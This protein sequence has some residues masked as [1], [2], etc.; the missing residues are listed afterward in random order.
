M[1]YRIELE[2]KYGT[3]A[4][5]CVGI[6]EAEATKLSR[7]EAW[8]DQGFSLEERLRKYAKT[9]W[10]SWDILDCTGRNELFRVRR[11]L[12]IRYGLSKTEQ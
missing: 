9:L 1:S 7:E 6:T 10:D 5:G 3:A 4:L 2:Q 11:I 12:A 8:L